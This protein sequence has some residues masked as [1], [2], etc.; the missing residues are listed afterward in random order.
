MYTSSL[1]LNI[2][3]KL[4]EN[5]WLS[6]LDRDCCTRGSEGKR[7]REVIVEIHSNGVLALA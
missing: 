4:Y 6:R 2:S 5:K 3:F 1:L 7:E